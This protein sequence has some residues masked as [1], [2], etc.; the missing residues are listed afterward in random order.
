MQA[1]LTRLQDL[2]GEIRRQLKPLGRQA[3]V[4]RRAAVVQADVRDARLRLLADDL[5][6]LPDDARGRRSP[7]RRRCASAAPRSRPALAEAAG[8]ARPRSSRPRAARTA[9]AGRGAGD[10]VRAVGAARAAPRHRQSLAAERVR[11][12]ARAE[13]EDARPGRDP[14]A[15]GGRGRS[16]CAPQEHEID[17]RGRRATAS[18]LEAAVARPAAGR[19]GA[20]PRRSAGSPALARAAADRREGLARLAG[21]V[22]ALRSTRRGR[23]GRDRPAR[24]ARAGRGARAERA[25]AA[26]SPPSR[27]RSP[28][29]TRARR[30]ST[31][32]TRRPPRRLA[33]AER[34]GST[35]LREEAARRRARARL[36]WPPARRPSSSASPA[37][38][39][40]APCSPPATGSSGLLGSVAALLT[41][42]SPATRPRSP[43]PSASAADA[44]A[45]S[46]VGRR[47]GAI[48]CLK[49]DD[50]GRAGLLVGGT[51]RPTDA[52]A[53]GPRCPAVRAYALDVVTAPDALR[54]AVGRLL[55]EVAVVDDLATA[56]RPGRTT[57]PTLVAVTREG[58]LL[59]AALA[60]GGSATHAEPARGAGRGRRG[61]AGSWPRRVTASSGC[62]STLR[63]RSRSRLDATRE[64]VEAA[65]DR[66]ARVRRPDGRGG[67]GA[68]PAR[69]RRPAPPAARPSGSSARSPPPQRGPRR[70]TVAGARRARATRLAAAEDRRPD[71]AEPDTTER[72]RARRGGPRGPPGRDRGPARAAHRRGAGPR[73]AR[74]GRPLA[75]AAAA[76]ARGPG[77]GRAR[78]ASRRAREAP[79]R[80]GGRRWPRSRRWRGSSVSLARAA[81]AREP[82]S[83]RPGPS[84]STSCW[85]AARPAARASA[86]SWSE[87]TDSVHRDEMARAEQRM[88]IEQLEEKAL[89]ELGL[90]AEALVAEYGPDQLVPPSPACARTRSTRGRARADAVRPRRAGEAAARRR[91]RAR[92]ARQGQ[93][94]GA[95]GVR[96][97]GGAAQVPHRAARGPQGDPHATC[98]TSSRRSTSGSS[99]S[100][101][102]PTHDVAREFERRLRPAVPR[103]RGP[104][105]AH[106]PRRHA[107]HRHRGRGPAAR[108]EGQ[109]ALA[110]LRRRAVADR[111][112]VAG[113]D[114]QGPAEPVLHHG[115][116]RGRARRHQPGPPA[117]DLR[118]AARDQPAAS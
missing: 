20:A 12:A 66:A 89:E 2:T 28:A 43:R 103:R 78:G 24:A 13:P 31:P 70:R 36:R 73:A 102:R 112:G 25:A 27:P 101:P 114:L 52:G 29:S 86:A 84:A 10:L 111:G 80:R 61:R 48:G 98:S 92:P 117:R 49:D 77:P 81:E 9:G 26:S 14:D 83:S 8:S 19:G 76:G 65:L 91:A 21:Q 35:A 54:P 16:G 64:R 50:L 30:T 41:R 72:E 38:T 1:N 74:P 100:S 7:T 82:A 75:R 118:G 42:A 46:D 106:R 45:V 69:R 105:G 55:A 63:P 79:W 33:D 5:V 62:G 18:A 3:E 37:R 34:R 115:R 95:G 58:D 67:R 59:G 94:A 44:V 11:N 17:G 116:G 4:A 99:R 88:R 15:A 85:R 87:L 23:R 56:R 97:A 108:Q 113:G 22:N 40:R 39:A 53:V 90:D 47:R 71:D 107:H 6:Q 32:S 109:A 93:P 110:A 104:A 60:A 68:R 51:G 57:G 96:G